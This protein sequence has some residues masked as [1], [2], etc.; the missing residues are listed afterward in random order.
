MVF[1]PRPGL[2]IRYD[3]LWKEEELAGQEH[4][5]K[6]RPCAII[7][8]SKQRDDESRNV[9]LC[10]ITHSPPSPG[11]SAVEIPP[12]VARNLN[13][14]SEQSWIKTHQVNTVQWHKD[15]IPYGVVPAYEGQWAFGQLPYELG[16]QAF[17][18]VH[19][20]SRQ[21]SLENV[22]RDHDDQFIQEKINKLR[23]ETMTTLEQSTEHS[24]DR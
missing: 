12:A 9:I 21:R 2:V 1:E 3:F 24:R 10:P 17:E 20:Q 8:A 15:Y 23:D 11:E 14:D 7:L 13:L 19:E 18:Q 6:D 22:R 4:G 16:K 5:R